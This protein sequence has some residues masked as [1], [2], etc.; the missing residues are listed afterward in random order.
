MR[1][2]I[3]RGRVTSDEHVSLYYR[4]PRDIRNEAFTHRMR[5]L[6]EDEVREYLDLL[7]DQTAAFERERGEMLDE[8]ERL[9]AAAEQSGEH[10]PSTPSSVPVSASD[11][12]QVQVAAV[13]THAQGV[14]DQ[15]LDDASRRAQDIVAAAQRRGHEVVRQ[16]RIRTLEQMQSLY[17]ELDEEFQGLGEAMRLSAP[18]R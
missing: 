15:L 6:D 11:G 8:L 3:G 14:A 1:A 13:L 16:A 10:A 18:D 4:S 17:D 9:R 2:P 12:G 5:G 7:A